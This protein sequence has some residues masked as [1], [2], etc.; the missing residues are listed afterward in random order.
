MLKIADLE[1]GKRNFASNFLGMREF[2]EDSFSL[3]VFPLL[4]PEP[5]PFC[6]PL[7][8]LCR[9]PADGML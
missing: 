1:Q 9:L 6:D 8:E 4:G 2:P 5:L 7:P 3:D